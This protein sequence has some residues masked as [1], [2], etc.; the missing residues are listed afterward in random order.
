MG[1]FLIVERG[2]DLLRHHRREHELLE[3]DSWKPLDDFLDEINS[4]KAVII[5]GGPGYQPDFYPE[6]YPLTK[7]LSDIKVPIIPFGL[8]WKG[9]PGDNITLYRYTFTSASMKLLRKIYRESSMISC[10]DYLTKEVLRRHDFDN[11]IMTGCPSLYDVKKIGKQFVAPKEIRK[12]VFTPAQRSL[13]NKQ[14]KQV[15]QVLKCMFPE[16]ERYCVFHRGWNV[17]KYTSENDAKNAQNLKKEAL[18]EGFKVVNAAYGLEKIAFYQECDLHIGYRLHGHIYFLS[19]RKPSFFLHED[20]RGKGFSETIS[21][22]SVQAWKRTLSG[23][24]A[25]KIEVSKVRGL[26]ARLYGIALPR[27]DAVWDLRRYIESEI[28]NNF[29]RF[30]GLDRVLDSY[31]EIMVKFLKS[32]P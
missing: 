6:V 8:G 32:L 10:R 19:Q 11:V 31:Y 23:L 7:R 12:L 26:V 30:R 24:I 13:Y 18:K 21:L 16:A 9:F 20:G 2:K 15:M 29:T 1:D 3:L 25:E 4:S 5:C 27:E 14:S 17:D 22:M 28:E